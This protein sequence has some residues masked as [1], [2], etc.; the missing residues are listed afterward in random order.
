MKISL[1]VILLITFIKSAPIENDKVESKETITD[2]ERE[3][4]FDIAY[5]DPGPAK[6]NCEKYKLTSTFVNIFQ[7][8]QKR[9][10]FSCCGADLFQIQVLGTPIRPTNFIFLRLNIKVPEEES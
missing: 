1:L 8:R 5:A 2:S 3:L 7:S 4:D 6:V 9:F 10:F